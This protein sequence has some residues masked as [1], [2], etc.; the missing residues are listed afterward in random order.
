VGGNRQ[1][2]AA[3]G[4]RQAASEGKIENRRWRMMN[5]E[6]KDPNARLAVTRA[7]RTSHFYR[8]PLAAW[9]RIPHNELLLK[10]L[11]NAA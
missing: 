11:I 9:L 10:G 1:D 7:R 3:T 8:F 5:H 4:K 2:E 6:T